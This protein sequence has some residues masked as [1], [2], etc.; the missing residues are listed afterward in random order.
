MSD[1]NK[2]KNDLWE[3]ANKLRAESNLK[4]GEFSIPVLGLIFLRFADFKFTQAQRLFAQDTA[5]L[6][7]RRSA[8]KNERVKYHKEGI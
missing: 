5:K 6:S 8:S 1:I 4:T 3:A 7:A 2:V